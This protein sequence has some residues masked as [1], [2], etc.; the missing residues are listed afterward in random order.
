[1]MWHK[2][3]RA[4]IPLALIVALCDLAPVWATTIRRVPISER[5]AL[6]DLVVVGKV[7]EIEDLIFEAE[8]SRGAVIFRNKRAVVKVT[9]RVLGNSESTQIRVELFS[10]ENQPQ[11]A[12]RMKLPVLRKNDDV[13]IFLRRCRGTDSY[14][15]ADGGPFG[16]IQGSLVDESFKQTVAQANSAARLLLDPMKSLQ[17]KEEDE[18][19]LT[20]QMLC[21]RY[22]ASQLR[23]IGEMKQESIAADESR[24]ILENLLLLADKNKHEFLIA[25]SRLGPTIEDGMEEPIWGVGGD[26]RTLAWVR[27]HTATFRIKKWVREMH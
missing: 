15:F 27:E 7:T 12:L 5:V 23:G 8:P 24:L 25:I 3:S 1:M 19:I 2:I 9:E 22:C 21:I 26:G 17:S 13:L 18:R 11:D 10:N 14:Q 20:A 16:A 6:A 4:I